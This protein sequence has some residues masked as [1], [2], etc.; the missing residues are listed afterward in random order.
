MSLAPETLVNFPIAV[1]ASA[2]IPEG[3]RDDILAAPY[4]D[5]ELARS[6]IAEHADDIAGVIVEPFQRIIPPVPGFLEALRTACTENGIVLIFDEVATGFRFAYGG[7]QERY[8]VVPDVCTLGK[9]I[10][11]GFPLAAI[12]GKA[13]IMAH[14]DKS[15]VGSEALLM[16]VGTLSGNPV[17]AVAGLKTLEILRRPGQYEKIYA[18]GETLMQAMSAQLSDVGH[19]HQV[20]GDT[21][22]FDVVFT[23]TPV[24]NY[25]DVVQGDKQKA[26]A[27]NAGLRRHGILKPPGKV[28]MS[29]A[30]TGADMAQTIE[31]VGAAARE[32]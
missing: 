25:R 24:R 31:A 14:F 28:Y 26:A 21:T 10:G 17:A 7:A 11:G 8:G 1:P 29:M 6:L 5:I 2:G 3:Q 32:I 20:V 18:D 15:K 27:F 30:L 16:R 12:A 22:L 23:E 19:A 9:I 13:E 4:N